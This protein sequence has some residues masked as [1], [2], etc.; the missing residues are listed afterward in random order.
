V[1]DENGAAT[2]EPLP[3]DAVEVVVNPDDP[4]R[5]YVVWLA[6]DCTETTI[7]VTGDVDP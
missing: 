2:L 1:T 5:R 3:P 6:P 4:T 7:T